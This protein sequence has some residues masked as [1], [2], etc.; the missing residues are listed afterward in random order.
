[1]LPEASRIYSIYV[2]LK[3]TGTK[4][5]AVVGVSVASSTTEVSEGEGGAVTAGAAAK[6][7]GISP[8][9]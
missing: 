6:G 3:P 8:K 1:M 7:F 2:V 9:A 5:G 4:A